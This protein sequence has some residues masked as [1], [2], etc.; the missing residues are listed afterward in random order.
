MRYDAEVAALRTSVEKVVLDLVVGPRS[1]VA[2]RRA[3]LPHIHT[4]AAFIGRRW[5]SPGGFPGDQLF[6]RSCTC[7]LLLM[8]SMLP[9]ILCS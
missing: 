3:I 7:V 9:A 4:L 1:S 6:M 8:L 5:A 2:T